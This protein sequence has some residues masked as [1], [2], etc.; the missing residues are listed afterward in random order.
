MAISEWRKQL[1]LGNV[2]SRELV[3]KHIARIEKI[4]NSLHSFLELTSERA[5]FEA[6]QIDEARR[7]G[8]KLPP[9]AG[10]PIAVKD[11]LC[12]K[13]VRTTCSSRMLEGFLPPYE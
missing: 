1:E 9:L 6:D 3:D 8:E 13:G 7:S 10:I 11:N 12:T 2:S 5:R 4:D